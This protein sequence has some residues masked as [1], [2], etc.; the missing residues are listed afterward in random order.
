MLNIFFFD[1]LSIFKEKFLPF[2]HPF[3]LHNTE[4]EIGCMYVCM[5]ETKIPKSHIKYWYA[6]KYILQSSL[7]NSELVAAQKILFASSMQYNI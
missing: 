6:V 4:S 1:V 5:I 7:F 2:H 3:T